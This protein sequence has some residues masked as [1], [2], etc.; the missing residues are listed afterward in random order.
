MIVG[1][2]ICRGGKRGRRRSSLSLCTCTVERVRVEVGGGRGKEEDITATP[3]SPR[4]AGVAASGPSSPRFPAAEPAVRRA[5]YTA[6]TPS[7]PPTT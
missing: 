3:G 7:S 6:D 5:C 4:Q 1:R 2:S